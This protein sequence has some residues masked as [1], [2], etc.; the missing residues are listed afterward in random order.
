M[1]RLWKIAV[2]ATALLA[3]SGSLAAESNDDPL[4][5]LSDQAAELAHAQH[6]QGIM[7]ADKIWNLAE[8]GYM[9]VQLHPALL[10]W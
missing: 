5:A 1:Y 10:S 4:V 3:M 2:A 9:E 7:L 6:A 8:L